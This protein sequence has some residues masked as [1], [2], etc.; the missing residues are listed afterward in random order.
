MESASEY[1]E[2]SFYVDAAELQKTPSRKQSMADESLSLKE[3]SRANMEEDEE[4]VLPLEILD[5]KEYFK[6]LNVIGALP[7]I[8]KVKTMSEEEIATVMEEK[9]NQLYEKKS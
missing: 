6:V 4:P 1:T 7:D 9:M 2:E 5:D 8:Q 3:T